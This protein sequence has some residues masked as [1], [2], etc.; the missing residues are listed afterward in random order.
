M[1]VLLIAKTLTKG[2]S[3]TGA[4][5]LLIALQSAGMV[6]TALDA[7]EHHRN[8]KYVS[9]LRLIERIYERIVHNK[10]THCMKL[11]AS[12]FNLRDLYFQYKPDVIQLCDVSAN[13]IHFGDIAD[14][15]CPIV[16]RL[17]DFWPYHGASHYAES[18]PKQPSFSD[19]LLRHLIFDGNNKPDLLVAPSHWLADRLSSE[20]VEVICN[21]VDIPPQNLN[22]CKPGGIL[23]LG[24]ISTDIFDE[25]KGIQ[26]LPPFL[27]A[28][29]RD[30]ELHVFGR[31]SRGKT[32][33]NFSNISVV[34]HP[35]F[36]PNE[37]IQVY[38]S[39]DVLLCPSK[40][41]NS[42]N[43]LTEAFSFGVPVVAQSGTGMETYVN[44]YMGALIDFQTPS[45]DNIKR[46]SAILEKIISEY[47]LF[48][49]T[50]RNFV[51]DKLS[52][53]MIGSQYKNLYLNLLRL[54][55]V[56]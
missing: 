56:D 28:V 41:D 9:F 17:S 36:S 19:F 4:R 34:R 52:P 55:A 32:L 16:H 5:N 12:T 21:A 44:N 10:S 53:H 35:P 20:N 6:V 2:G 22:R 47:E 54:V 8:R 3:A 48:S 18:T 50:A 13:T 43:V 33:L 7:Y 25:R 14:V 46:F 37:L 15:G 27:D 45:D 26:F 23:R 39:F 31:L 11:G 29:H 40:S 38:N 24:F 51:Q 42:P 30:I 1:K 49:N